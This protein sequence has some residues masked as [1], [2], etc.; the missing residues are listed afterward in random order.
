V[1]SRYVVSA[2]VLLQCVAVR[3][4]ESVAVSVAVSSRGAVSTRWSCCNMLQC[5]AVRVD[6]S[7]AVCLC[8]SECCS[9]CCRVP[10]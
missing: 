7:V 5:V 9:E 6:V 3:V 10:S 4:A 2:R 1:S 8:C